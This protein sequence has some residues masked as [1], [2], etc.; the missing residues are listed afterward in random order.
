V[1]F[2]RPLDLRAVTI[3]SKNVHVDVG[4]Y[5]ALHMALNSVKV[6]SSILVYEE[7]N[8]TIST[9]SVCRLC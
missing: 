7:M 5:T 3:V 6:T 2:E 9:H 1:Q 4:V 8:T